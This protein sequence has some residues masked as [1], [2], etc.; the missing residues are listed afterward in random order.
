[1]R[2]YPHTAKRLIVAVSLTLQLKRYCGARITAAANSS[3][4]TSAK[5]LTKSPP[6]CAPGGWPR[7]GHLMDGLL[8]AN[9]QRL[10]I[11]KMTRLYYKFRPDVRD[12]IC[13]KIT[14]KYTSYR[15][16]GIRPLKT[17][18]SRGVTE[19]GRRNQ[20]MLSGL[21][22]LRLYLAKTINSYPPEQ[23]IITWGWFKRENARLRRNA[24]NKTLFVK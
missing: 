5:K 18:P 13:R 15:R 17:R 21:R 1:M 22:C 19:L 14:A 8:V 3:S 4:A 23:W 20:C 6:D 2:I 16:I 24:Y 7:W 12:S 11:T 10:S 9:A